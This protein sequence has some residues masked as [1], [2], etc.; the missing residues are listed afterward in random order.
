M[1]FQI[2]TNQGEFSAEFRVRFPT[3]ANDVM[4]PTELSGAILTLSTGVLVPGS[5]GSNFIQLWYEKVSASSGTGN[6]YL[7]SSAGRL[8]MVSASIFDDNFYNI[9]IV[10]EAVTGTITLSAVRYDED[11]LMFSSSSFAVSGSPGFPVNAVYN[12]LELGCSVIR[13][14]FGQFWGQE[15]RAWDCA[16]TA[17]EL[18]SHARHFDS[19]GRETSWNNKDL[20][21]HWRLDSGFTTNTAGQIYVQ[22]ISKN[23]VTGTGSNYA[24][25]ELVSTKFLENYAYIPSIDYG[26]NQEKVRTFVGSKI[27]LTGAYHDERFVSLEF[28][29]YDALNENISQLM[30]SYDELNNMLGLPMNKWR[31]SYEGLQQMRETYFK[32]LQGQLD[33][34]VFASMLD[35][36]DST[37]VTVVE[38]LLPARTLFK[39]DELVVE[40]HMLERPKYQYQIR[41]IHEVFDL[42]G[43]IPMTYR[44]E[45][46][47]IKQPVIPAINGI[48]GFS[49]VLAGDSNAYG[50]G[51]DTDKA[52]PSF[53]ITT[54]YSFATCITSNNIGDPTTAT[55]QSRGPVQPFGPG[56]GP[57]FG[58]EIPM[59]KYLVNHG[60]SGGT[61]PRIIKFT[62]YGRALDDW[63]PTSTFPT[64]PIGVQNILTQAFAQI[65]GELAAYGTPL[66]A[67]VY[68]SGANDALTL[69]LANNYISNLTG[70][71]TA[72]RARYGANVLLVLTKLHVNT[73]PAVCPYVANVRAAQIAYAASDPN[74]V[75][76]DIDDTE[77]ATDNRH[78]DASGINAIG[79]RVADAIGTALVA[80]YTSNRSSGPAPYLQGW[81]SISKSGGSV[82]PVIYPHKAN[83]WLYLH[84]VAAGGTVTGTIATPSG[85]TAVTQQIASAFSNTLFTVSSVFRRKAVS[86]G[87][88]APTIAKPTGYSD[89]AARVISIRN[90]NGT[91]PEDVITGGIGDTV[92]GLSISIPGGTT[93]GV[94]RLVMAMVGSFDGG[95][96]AHSMTALGTTN[97]NLATSYFDDVQPSANRVGMAL[98]VATVPTATTY[99]A[100]TGSLIASYAVWAGHTIAIEP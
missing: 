84:A 59:A 64:N 89:M 46:V 87:T 7:T 81:E 37:F 60:A 25:N 90:A 9:A 53:N 20:Q 14:T 31:E 32:R 49:V 55:T 96:A 56:G 33:F 97:I 15:A 82:T 68:A 22:D 19:F 27:P 8:T 29:M 40:S 47:N 83:D 52:D 17:R 6:L 2:G 94:N 71:I 41:P 65:D 78:W 42:T 76:V 95:G 75:L 92:G 21:L 85:W 70:Y 16:L 50:Y 18:D 58:I 77:L 43:I 13:Q 54:P 69:T 24:P 67:I 12:K 1:F 48:D 23:N 36:F 34:N 88:V 38:K 91:T 3:A 57:G 98:S 79:N 11:E 100:V 63:Q 35:F 61:I 80:G 72:M 4:Q 99:G 26:W 44:G 30:S 28:N 39:G 10:K 5:S 51:G 73:D 74:C 66:K 62:W 45:P 86:S 93:T